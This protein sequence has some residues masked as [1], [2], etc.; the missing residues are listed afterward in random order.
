MILV[1]L[2]TSGGIFT[3][4]HWLACNI[5]SN[6]HVLPTRAIP[7]Q[8]AVLCSHCLGLCS[9]PRWAPLMLFFFL[10]WF[11]SISLPSISFS[12]ASWFEKSSSAA[13][14]WRTKGWRGWRENSA[15]TAR[16]GWLE[17]HPSQGLWQPTEHGLICLKGERTTWC[18]PRTTSAGCSEGSLAESC[19]AFCSVK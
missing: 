19:F 2:E 13:G 5:F 10:F 17:G 8:L 1:S 9:E 11:S 4:Y 16:V 6:R 14:R 12:C 3:C 18:T 15:Q 7:E